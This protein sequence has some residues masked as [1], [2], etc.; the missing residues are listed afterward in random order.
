MK[1][2]LNY[3]WEKHSDAITFG[4][5]L[6]I[7]FGLMIASPIQSV[8]SIGMG[9]GLTTIGLLLFGI[10][11]GIIVVPLIGIALISLANW[12]FNKIKD[13]TKAYRTWKST[14]DSDNSI[15]GEKE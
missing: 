7:G 6:A 15:Q 9:N 1:T 5:W 2:Y 14:S 12:I 13:S 3:L 10:G 11:I 8:L 4:V